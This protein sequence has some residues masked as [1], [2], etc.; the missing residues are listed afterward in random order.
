MT[1]SFQPAKEAKNAERM[2]A[3]SHTE[4][5]LPKEVTEQLAQLDGISSQLRI[6]A[7]ALHVHMAST[8]TATIAFSKRAKLQIDFI[9]C[10]T[11]VRSELQLFSH[12]LETD[13]DQRWRPASLCPATSTFH[14]Q[15]KE[16]NSK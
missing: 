5:P 16:H 12:S 11:D 10:I 6:L 9:Q 1:D 13:A 2:S 4:E 8:K 15:H 7:E 3:S 14:A